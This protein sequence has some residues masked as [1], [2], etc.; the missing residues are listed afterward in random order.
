MPWK[1]ETIT[2]FAVVQL[3]RH[4]DICTA[5][6]YSALHCTALHLHDVDG[7]QVRVAEGELPAQELV[8]LDQLFVLRDLEDLSGRLPQPPVR[9]NLGNCTFPPSDNKR[10]M[11]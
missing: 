2:P 1:T 10:L 6:R 4:I 3:H 7:V 11:E 5:L 8:A 9:N